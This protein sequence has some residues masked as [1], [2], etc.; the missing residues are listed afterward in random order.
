MTTKFRVGVTPDFQAQAKGS[1]EAALAEALPNFDWEYMPDTGRDAAPE[2]LD[3]YD[4]VIAL[5]LH[6]PAASVAGVKRLAV[7]TRWGVGY[8][9]LDVPAL[10]DNDVIL[11]ITPDGVRR[12]VAEGIITF[13][14]ALAKN[15][16]TLDTLC[17]AGRWRDSAP[18]T[19]QNVEG[20]TLGSVGAGNIAGEMF[21]I[22]RGIG[23][24]RLLA[25]D[26][27]VQAAPP[28]VELVPLETVM[29]ESDFV[30]INCFL[31]DHTRNLIGAREIGWMKP[32]AYLI[33]T[34]R[35]PIV[36][37]EALTDAL[38][39]RRI[40]GAGLDVFETEP[41]PPGDPLLAMDNVI[42]APHAIAW[43]RE[44]ARDNGLYA[45]RNVLA[46]SR[47]EAPKHVVNREV[48]ARPGCSARLARWR[49]T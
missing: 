19:A 22:A 48:L 30:A 12:P 39:S 32:T 4:G 11:A 25:C 45:C 7:I 8:D 46:V 34:A 36:N 13:I 3:R 44:S 23:F 35:G 2:V 43:T 42:V 27:F 1:I 18:P 9:R 21:R 40:A 16:R 15:L 10:T 20:K 14:F 28:G 49:T 6:F 5:G 17:R 37:R 31:N 47:G 29:R 33:N 24:G 38:R 41:V 26:P